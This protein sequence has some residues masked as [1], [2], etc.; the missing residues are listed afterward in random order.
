MFLNKAI[1]YGNIVRDLELKE[2]PSGTAV[3][4]LAVATNRKW[5]D[6]DGTKQ[7]DA[8]FHN[9]VIFG[10]MAENVANYL[11]KGSGILVEGRLQ[12]RSWESKDG[13]KKY[14]TEIVA[15]SVQFGPKREGSGGQSNA[16]SQEKPPTQAKEAV[17]DSEE[18][19]AS[20]VPF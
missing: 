12:T 6:K 14:M 11:G 10:K 19:D 4:N 3:C 8:Q 17:G 5:T 9:V 15:E 1:I 18:V 16:Q 2:L 13:V 7:E 20:D